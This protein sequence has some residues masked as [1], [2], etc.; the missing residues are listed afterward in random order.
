MG[1]VG[2]KGKL[3]IS[4]SGA[5]VHEVAWQRYEDVLTADVFGAYRYRSKRSWIKWPL[6]G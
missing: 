3:S 5:D 6:R 4:N 1:L 2:R